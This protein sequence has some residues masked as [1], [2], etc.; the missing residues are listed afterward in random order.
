M[1]RLFTGDYSSGG[2]TQWSRNNNKYFSIESV[3]HPASG[4]YPAAVIID[5]PDAGYCARFECRD[6]D[7]PDVE[8]DR[9]EVFGDELVYA[10]EGTTRWYAM[11]FKFDE[12]FPNNRNEL[13]WCTI[14]QWKAASISPYNEYGSPVINL[15]WASPTDP[16]YEN[17]YVHL[18]WSPQ[19][20][21]TVALTGS[22]GPILKIPINQGQWHDFKMRAYWKKDNTG[23]IQVWHNGVRQ[24]F[25]ATAGYETASTTFTGQTVCGGTGPTGVTFHQGI[26]RNT[27]ATHTD[28]VYHR[29]FRIADSEDSL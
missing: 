10:A 16:G 27:V 13:Q 29:G 19:S 22:G 25:N 28:I 20:E 14:A 26:Y 11:S 18:I 21:P 1:T 4:R 15:G 5:D 8:S 23:T 17:G 3:Y 2:F 9:S 6:G 7:G 24:T 12:S